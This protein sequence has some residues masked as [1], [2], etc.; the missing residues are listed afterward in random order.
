VGTHRLGAGFSAWIVVDVLLV[1]VTGGL[2]QTTYDNMVRGRVITAP[3][4][5]RIVIIDIDESALARMATEFGRWPWPRDTLATVLDYVEEQQPA[6]VVWDIIFSDVDRLNP[7]GDAA[8]DAAAK[9]SAHSHFGLVRLPKANDDKSELTQKIYLACGYK[10][11]HQKLKS[12]LRLRS[13][14]LYYLALQSSPLVTTTA[15]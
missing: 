8:F 4:D 1:G 10:R 7:G 9:R 2:A 3:A 14:R 15:M 5:P 12:S 11:R 13:Y 6:A